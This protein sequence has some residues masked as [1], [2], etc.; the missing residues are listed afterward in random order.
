VG[1]FWGHGSGD[2]ALGF[3]TANRIDHD[4]RADIVGLR[5][6][7]ERRID[8]LFEAMADATQEAVLDALAAATPVVGR[9]GATRPCLYD[10]LTSGSTP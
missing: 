5:M 2:I 7:N 6:L 4:E 3:T 8:S 10:L 1:S 9:D